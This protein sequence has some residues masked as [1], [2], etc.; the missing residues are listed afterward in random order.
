MISSKKKNYLFFNAINKY[1]EQKNI[2]M[3]NMIAQ[4]QL[5][6]SNQQ[7]Q[8]NQPNQFIE[9][10]QKPHATNIDI[11]PVNV[12]VNVNDN[13]PIIPSPPSVRTFESV[14]I[15][16]LF[17]DYDSKMY[18]IES[19]TEHCFFVEQMQDE[20]T[21]IISS[22]KYDALYKWASQYDDDP[23]ISV[24]YSIFYYDGW[25][26]PKLNHHSKILDHLF[27]GKI[28]ADLKQTSKESNGGNQIFG[29]SYYPNQITK[30][31][32][33]PAPVANIVV[34]VIGLSGVIDPAEISRYWQSYCGIPVKNHPKIIVIPADKTSI[35]PK[36]VGYDQENT[37]DVELMGGCCANDKFGVTIVLYHAENT[38]QGFY[39]AFQYAISDNVYNPSVISCSWGISETLYTSYGTSGIN[40]MKAFD[41]LFAK[42]VQKGINICCSSGDFAASDGVNDGFPHVDFPA[43]SPNVVSC[44]GTT[45][46]APNYIYDLKTTETLWSFNVSN[47]MGTGAGI[48]T[49]FDKP[50]YQKLV[51]DATV[52]KRGICDISSN[53]DPNTG[54][55]ILYGGKLVITGGT[56]CASPVIGA[57]IACSSPRKFINPIIYRNP[58]A[59]HKI[60]SGSNGYYSSDP[61]GNYS[62]CSGMGS[63]SA[64][65]AV[66]LRG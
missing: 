65:L 52:T 51:L 37:T 3:A 50:D 4:H 36:V 5:I 28:C 16:L 22:Y 31:Y 47:N 45:L 40:Q 8:P 55:K 14:I 32:G 34:G 41:N 44:G 9:L 23:N 59:F 19:A 10:K 13:E 35:D 38:I 26:T 53:S 43:S 48:S 57:F 39:S 27:I 29:L 24:M 6:L 7:N 18:I 46:S 54:Y 49:V 66:V 1:A 15:T 11:D 33:F 12:N 20:I 30:I 58:Q 2:I 21:L 25:K 42:A 64:S 63:P 62:L 61:L 56:S 17:D 60:T